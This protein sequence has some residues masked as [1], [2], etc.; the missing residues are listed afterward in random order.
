MTIDLKSGAKKG[1]GEMRR[2]GRKQRSWFG[3]HNKAI[4]QSFLL[5]TRVRHYGERER[6][7]NGEGREGLRRGKSGNEKGWFISAVMVKPP[8][9]EPEEAIPIKRNSLHVS[10]ESG[11]AQKRTKGGI[12]REGG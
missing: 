2:I 6:M 8:E 12:E 5:H 9:K 1:G 10:G 7:K 4:F 3:S 11:G